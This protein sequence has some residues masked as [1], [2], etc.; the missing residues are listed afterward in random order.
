MTALRF[1]F[2]LIWSAILTQTI[3]S[4]IEA[5]EPWMPEEVTT[6]SPFFSAES[7]SFVFF[8]CLRIGASRTK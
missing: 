7:I 2:T 5:I 1:I 4:S 8:C 3:C 6:R